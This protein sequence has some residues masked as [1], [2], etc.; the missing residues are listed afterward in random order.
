V[1]SPL[2]AGLIKKRSD[3]VRTSNPSSRVPVEPS[4]FLKTRLQVPPDNSGIVKKHFIFVVSVRAIVVAT[5]SECPLMVSLAVIPS[6][7]FDPM[8]VM[9]MY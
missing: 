7:K 2:R 4:V 1:I 5:I 8:T 9:G 3:Q 6:W